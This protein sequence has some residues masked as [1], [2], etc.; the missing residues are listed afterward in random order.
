MGK[1]RPGSNLAPIAKPAVRVLPV[2][3]QPTQAS[4]HNSK[5]NLYQDKQ[6]LPYG[7][8][9]FLYQFTALS[10]VVIPAPQRE[11]SN[12]ANFFFSG[13]RIPVQDDKL[14][15]MEIINH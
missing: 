10:R 11:S 8:F 14:K 2:M 7:G 4:T 13:S 1:K 5:K 6:K 15:I 3:T 12:R 9:C